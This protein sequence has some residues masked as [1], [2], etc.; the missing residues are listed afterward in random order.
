MFS[1]SAAYYFV[2][3]HAITPLD[4]LLPYHIQSFFNILAQNV[5]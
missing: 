5:I 4:S 1:V 3:R 2:S